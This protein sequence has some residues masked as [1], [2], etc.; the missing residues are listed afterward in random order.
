LD[1]TATNQPVNLQEA[2]TRYT[3]AIRMLNSSPILRILFHAR[4]V[5]IVAAL[6]AIP[7]LCQE[8]Q[9]LRALIAVA[10]IDHAN[11]VAAARSTLLAERDGEPDPLWYLRDELAERGQFP[12]PHGGTQA[13]RW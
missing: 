2:L 5:V 1:T 8:I 10:S 3:N 12:R 7:G 6:D 9:H 4:T 13:A 11:L